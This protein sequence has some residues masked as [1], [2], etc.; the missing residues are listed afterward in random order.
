M[1][2]PSHGGVIYI[3]TNPSFPE[4]VKIGYTTNLEN[5]LRQLNRSETL[6]YSF[7]AYAIY[8]VNHKL[9]DKRLHAL[10]DKLNPDLR[11]VETF[12]GKKR[13][14][15]FF[16]MSAEDAYEILDAIA[17]I[18]GTE[19][20]LRRVKPSGEEIREEQSAEEA[21][22]KARRP[23]FRFSM[24]GISPGETLTFKDDSN[25]IAEVVDDNHVRV[26]KVTTS[27]S[28]SAQEIKGFDHPVQGTLWWTYR[29]TTLDD[30]RRR[31]ES[32]GQAD[33]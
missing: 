17:K 13:A 22:E 29:G 3:L 11:A 23:P 12:N 15:E 1:S 14:R 5:R 7:R 21:R 19:D 2:A 30:L 10:I 25:I 26:G 33:R 27:L 6:P 28:A 31:T 20:R 4:Y 32:S 16:E 24:V 9:T 8:E 18:S